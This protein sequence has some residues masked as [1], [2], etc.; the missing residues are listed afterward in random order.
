MKRRVFEYLLYLS[1]F[2]GLLF[3]G[4]REDAEAQIKKIAGAK[5]ELAKSVYEIPDAIKNQIQ[6]SAGQKFFRPSLHVWRVKQSDGQVLWAVMDNVMGKVQPFTF[7]VIFN[8]NGVIQWSGVLKYREDHGGQVQHAS[9]QKQF[10]GRNASSGWDVH[11]DVDAITGAT[12]SVH[13][14]TRGLHKL[15]LLIPHIIKSESK[16]NE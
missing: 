13:S 5:T 6:K 9:W 12:I 11:S 4:L 3:S 1:L 2:P 10:H 14:Y 15:S 7:L 8:Q 16:E